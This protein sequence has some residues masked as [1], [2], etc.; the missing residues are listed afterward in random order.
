M[1]YVPQ[2][3]ARLVCM[4]LVA[5]I[6][7]GVGLSGQAHA[8][9]KYAGIV[10]DH[11]TGEVLYADSADAPR[12][13]ASLTKVMT[14]Y[15]VFDRLRT[16]ELRLD[17]PMKVSR[18]AAAQEPSKLYLKPGSTITV[19]NAIKALVTKSAND[20]AVVV[21]EHIAGSVENFAR[22]MNRKAREIG[23][24]RTTFRNPNGLPDR[25]QKTTARDMAIMGRAI[26]HEHPDYFRY[27]STSSFTYRGRRYG[28]HNR[29][30]GR[31]PGVN[32]IKTGYTR[33]SGFNLLT[34]LQRDGRHLIA[35]VMG[36]RTGASRNAH[37]KDLLRRTYARASVRPETA[38]APVVIAAAPPPPKVQRPDP[39][40]IIHKRF[41]QAPTI[42][43]IIAS[44]PPAY[45]HKQ[46]EH[47]QQERQDT[48]L[49]SASEEIYIGEGDASPA[50]SVQER[51]ARRVNGWMVQIGAFDT[52]DQAAAHLDRAQ[53]RLG[54][55]LANVDPVTE[56]F[57][58]GD[59]LFYRA[60]FAGFS[61]Q[62]EAQNACARLKKQS[63]ACY[64]VRD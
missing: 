37:M 47:K 49:A 64:A 42:E 21:A 43:S 29:L 36:G 61:S 24:T 44:L 60:R 55:Q 48:R 16:G 7:L 12:Y 62:Q 2:R 11:N 10:I 63:F 34:S 14:L 56:K 50:A 51:P 46:E 19:E 9:S 4:F 13:P 20:A 32:G 8:N 30:L 22:L 25:E 26:Y 41:V 59:A 33:A 3:F 18:R 28:N 54:R 58:R 1:R 53:N 23:M 45:E 52:P 40:S 27:F 6:A 15:L 31:V 39:N 57:D 35:V 17:E 38:P 5:A